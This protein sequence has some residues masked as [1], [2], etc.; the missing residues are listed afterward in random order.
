ME[1]KRAKAMIEVLETLTNEGT[2]QTPQLM[3]WLEMFMKHTN[4]RHTKR[5]VKR[6]KAMIIKAEKLRV[7]KR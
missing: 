6:F 7:V 4:K 1:Y 2:L 5:I 3:G